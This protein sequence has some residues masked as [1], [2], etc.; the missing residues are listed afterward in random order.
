MQDVYKVRFYVTAHLMQ[1]VLQVSRPVYPWV[2]DNHHVASKDV[3]VGVF[4][5]VIF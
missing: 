5:V 4:S 1:K 3:C 2:N